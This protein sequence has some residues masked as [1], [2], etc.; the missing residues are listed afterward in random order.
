M[1]KPGDRRWYR[2]CSEFCVFS[3]EWILVTTTAAK[4]QTTPSTKDHPQMAPL[5]SHPTSATYTPNPSKPLISSPALPFSH[6][7]KIVYETI[8]DVIF[9]E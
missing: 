3:Y 5:Q 1:A 9:S 6:L 8:H 4:M 7:G 2:V